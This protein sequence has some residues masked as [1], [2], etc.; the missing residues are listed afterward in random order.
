MKVSPVSAD[1]LI[2]LAMGAAAVGVVFYGFKRLSGAVSDTLSSGLE[3]LPSR[4]EVADAL[5]P[6]S[7]QNL[8]YKA[9]NNV[10]Q[11]LPAGESETLGTWLHKTFSGD[12]ERVAA[13][14]NPKPFSGGSTGSW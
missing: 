8:A 4:Q 9:A 7:D 14:L 5:N 6:V 12:D 13:A 11:Y 2:K 10:V 1:L 3:Y